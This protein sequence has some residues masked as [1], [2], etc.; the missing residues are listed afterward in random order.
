MLKIV[1]PSKTFTSVGFGNASTLNVGQDVHA[2]GHLEGEVWTYRK[3]TSS[4][5]RLV[6]K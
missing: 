2:V 5:I 6:Y 4:Q 3:G 1:S